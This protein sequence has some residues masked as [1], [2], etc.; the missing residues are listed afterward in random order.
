MRPS[1]NHSGGFHV[2]FVGGSAR[3]MSDDMPYTLYAQL[4]TPY[5]RNCRE[6]GNGD[7]SNNRTFDQ[8]AEYQWV[9][10]IVDDADLK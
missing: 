5:G 8:G 4:M 1:S 2:T 6:P 7:R 9:A 3:F 10:D